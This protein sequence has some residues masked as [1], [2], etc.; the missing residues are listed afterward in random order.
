MSAFPT[1]LEG[2]H[3]HRREGGVEVQSPPQG[4]TAAAVG[5]DVDVEGHQRGGSLW[6][7]HASP[8]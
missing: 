4:E 5:M 6:P 8:L 1:I 3:I 7:P 2:K